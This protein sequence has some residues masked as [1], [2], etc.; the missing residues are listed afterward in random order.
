MNTIRRFNVSIRYDSTSN[1]Q[2]ADTDSL[3]WEM[4]ELCTN[5]RASHDVSVS[6]DTY[7]TVADL[8][9]VPASPSMVDRM[10]HALRTAHDVIARA[11]GDGWEDMTTNELTRA[12]GDTLALLDEYDRMR[13]VPRNNRDTVIAELIR[14][15]DAMMAARS[16]SA[17]DRG[18]AED[19]AHAAVA[20]AR[21]YDVRIMSDQPET[22]GKCGARTDFACVDSWTQRHTCTNTRC[23]RYAIPFYVVDDGDAARDSVR[24]LPD[25]IAT[26]DAFIGVLRSIVDAGYSESLGDHGSTLCDRLGIDDARDEY[27]GALS[28]AIDETCAALGI[29]DVAGD[30]RGTLYEW[31]D[32]AGYAWN[33]DGAVNEDSDDDGD[34][35]GDR[36][37]CNQCGGPEGAHGCASCFDPDGQ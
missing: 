1:T 17:R 7:T 11:C 14:G 30:A 37:C 26:R 27:N 8:R 35:D 4:R 18:V 22:C 20:F 6:F 34:D 29:G 24:D 28:N 33:A 16:L 19:I 21:G 3:C 10:A 5:A 15:I 25:A 13:T 9:R 36:G 12:D 32:A 23:T 31:A 2:R